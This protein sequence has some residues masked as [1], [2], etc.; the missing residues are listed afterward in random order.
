MHGLILGPDGRLYW[1]I[2]DR[3]TSTNL[4]SQMKKP[5]PGLTPETLA[6]AG[7]VFRCAPDGSE[8]EI[9]ATGLRN[10]QELAFDDEG[11]LF[12]GDNNGDGG[13][14]ARW[15]Y[16]VEGADHGWRMGWQWLPK[17]GAW[18]SE[19]LWANAPTNHAAYIVPSLAHIAR[20]PAGLAFTPGTG[21]PPQYDNHFF[22]CD[23]PSDVLTW[24]NQP[25]RGLL[26]GRSCDAFFRQARPQRHHL[27]GG[28][29]GL[30]ERLDPDL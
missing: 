11:N 4:L 18:N 29:G 20:G 26:R 7:A 12:T 9:F 19:K 2:A 28:R 27:R 22:L 23:F 15:H 6:D 17:M 1:S 8:F 24:T 21:L 13:D 25:A 14:P 5:F 16:V 10:P 3:G 30:C